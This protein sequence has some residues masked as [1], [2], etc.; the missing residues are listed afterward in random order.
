MSINKKM[1]WQISINKKSSI[2]NLRNNQVQVLTAK[3]LLSFW[4][5]WSQQNDYQLFNSF[6]VSKQPSMAQNKIN[7]NKNVTIIQCQIL[8]QTL[9][10][11][12]CQ[13][14]P[15]SLNLIL[16]KLLWM[17]SSLSFSFCICILLNKPVDN[18]SSQFS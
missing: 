14:L 16:I 9:T 6:K 4:L 3:W 17:W 13:F 11:I 15:L 8:T 18:F 2:K 7:V 5:V 1:F 12:Q 10:L